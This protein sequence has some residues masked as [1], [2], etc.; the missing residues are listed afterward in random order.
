MAPDEHAEVKNKSRSTYVR[1]WEEE[2][3]LFNN[4]TSHSQLTHLLILSWKVMIDNLL[5][6]NL[7]KITT[8]KYNIVTYLT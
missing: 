1:H 3:S 4:I 8:L 5:V 2:V 7:K 6:R